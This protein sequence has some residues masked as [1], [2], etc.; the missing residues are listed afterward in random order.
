MNVN[1]CV[2]VS[3]VE[4]GSLDLCASPVA[5]QPNLHEITPSQQRGRSARQRHISMCGMSRVSKRGLELLVFWDIPTYVPS[6]SPTHQYLSPILLL[7]V[8]GCLPQGFLRNAIKGIEQKKKGEKKYLRIRSLTRNHQ[9]TSKQKKKIF[10]PSFS[11]LLS[12]KFY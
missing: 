8:G 12:A 9:I 7:H 1:V 2:C 5:R 3:R 11:W 10:F 4:R 6:S